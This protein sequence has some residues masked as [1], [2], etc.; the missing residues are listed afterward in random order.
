MRDPAAPVR[1]VHLLP[2][3]DDAGAE[4]QARYLLAGLRDCDW[5][6]PELA[7]F[8]AG[9]AHRDFAELGVPMLH[10]ARLRRLRWDLYGRARRLRRAYRHAPPAI[11]HT[12]L[13]EANVIGLLAARAWPETRVVISQRG[14]WNELDY[15]GL[16]RLQRVLLHGAAHAVSNSDGGAE[17]LRAQGVP[18]ERISVISNGIPAERA[19]VDRPRTV[20]RGEMGWNGDEIVAWVGRAND[21]ATVGHKD[22]HT[23]FEA[24]DSLRRTRPSVR[25]AMIGTTASELEDR[26]LRL[27]DGA[28]ALGW[29]S[30]PAELLTPPT[31]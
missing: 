29:Q 31:P 27:P 4:N 8:G 17:M 5:L 24:M 16:V 22:L 23:L 15:P 12:W 20:T 25:L 14:S 7:Y 11:L 19:R 9:R 21:Q 3:T 26:G 13:L 30:R 6:E 1:C 10:L 2:D 18:A 28:L